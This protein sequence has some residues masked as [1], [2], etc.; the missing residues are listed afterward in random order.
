MKEL[1]TRGCQNPFAIYHK[2]QYF[3]MLYSNY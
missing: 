2:Y 1:F 3:K